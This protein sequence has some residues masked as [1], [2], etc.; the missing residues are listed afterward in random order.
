[1]KISH[2]IDN[3][4]LMLAHLPLQEIKEEVAVGDG[5]PNHPALS[6]TYNNTCSTY[7]CC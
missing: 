1:M 6:R 4:D 5:F 3:L 2:N 7:L